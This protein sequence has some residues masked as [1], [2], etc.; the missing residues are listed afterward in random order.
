MIRI[1]L[2]HGIAGWVALCGLALGSG[3]AAAQGKY[4]HPDLAA[5]FAEAVTERTRALWAESREASRD[6]PVTVTI[7]PVLTFHRD[8]VGDL[9]AQA[10]VMELSVATEA[11]ALRLSAMAAAMEAIMARVLNDTDWRGGCSINR[12]T[13]ADHRIWRAIDDLAA[14]IKVGWTGGRSVGREVPKN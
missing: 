14:D 11:E 1:R 13:E 12:R 10:T 6:L 8:W 2:A 7:G 3:P 9:V 5:C 4:H